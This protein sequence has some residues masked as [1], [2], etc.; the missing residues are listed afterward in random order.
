M[1]VALG[2]NNTSYMDVGWY[3]FNVT[4]LEA[5]RAKLNLTGTNLSNLDGSTET[6]WLYRGM[7]YTFYF[8]RVP[9]KNPNTLDVNITNIVFTGNEKEA[10]LRLVEG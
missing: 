9:Y 7:N 4:S 5:N 6:P 10:L 2:N 1:Y 8:N 3:G